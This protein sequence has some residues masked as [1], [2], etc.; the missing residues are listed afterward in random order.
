MAPSEEHLPVNARGDVVPGHGEEFYLVP[1]HVCPTV[2]LAAR[3][4]VM[5]RDPS[6]GELFLHSVAEIEARAHDTMLSEPL[7]SDSFV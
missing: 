5:D 4:I 2:N 7:V 3:A 1:R 6:T